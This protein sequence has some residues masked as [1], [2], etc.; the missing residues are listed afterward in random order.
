MTETE[1]M[2]KVVEI[3]GDAFD[4]IDEL[5]KFGPPSEAFWTVKDTKDELIDRA[6]LITSRL[7]EMEANT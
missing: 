3:L 1:V 6:A 4:R 7:I 5:P 2:K